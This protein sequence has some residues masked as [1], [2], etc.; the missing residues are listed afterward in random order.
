[1]Q[2]FAFLWF[3]LQMTKQYLQEKTDGPAQSTVGS[4]NL[5]TPT[6]AGTPLGASP[7]QAA[8]M[9]SAMKRRV[10]G[11]LSQSLL[12]LMGLRFGKFAHNRDKDR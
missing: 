2:W 12:R 6:G 9:A 1:M 7:T 11:S 8:P 5:N 4:A 10:S 3:Q